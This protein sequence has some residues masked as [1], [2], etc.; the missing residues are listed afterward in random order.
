VI[1]GRLVVEELPESKEAAAKREYALKRAW[2]GKQLDSQNHIFVQ[3]YKVPAGCRDFVPERNRPELDDIDISPQINSPVPGHD[4]GILVGGAKIFDT[5]SLRQKLAGIVSQLASINAFSQSQI[6]AQYGSFQG[7]TRDTSYLAAQLT[8]S[9]TPSVV[10]TAGAATGNIVTTA[11]QPNTSIS[12]LQA[13]CP[14]GYLPQL[15]AGNAITCTIVNGSTQPYPV[16]AQTTTAN[17]LTNQ[18]VATANLPTNQIQTTTPSLTGTVPTAPTLNPLAP[19]AGA[20]ISSADMLDLQMQLGS[21]LTTLQT[22]LLGATSDQLLLSHQRA[23]GVRSQT[24]IGF[25]IT[26]LTPPAY[27]G[28]AA[29]VRMLILPR[30]SPLSQSQPKISIVNLLPL[31]KTYNV[32]RIT[33]NSKAFGAAVAIQPVSLGVSTGKAKDRLYL[34]K[35]TDTVALQYQPDGYLPAPRNWFYEA[36]EPNQECND[37]PQDVASNRDQYDFASAV[38]FG[39]QF[40]PVLGAVAVAPGLRTTFAQLALPQSDGAE[41]KPDVWVQ[42][43]WR[44]YDQKGQIAGRIYQSS[45]HW[46]KL[47]DPVSISNPIVVK[48]LQVDDVGQGLLRFRASGDFFSSTGQLRSGSLNVPPQFF[49]GNTIEYF[50]PAKDF[51]SNGDLRVLDEAMHGQPL[52]IPAKEE[53]FCRIA[54][55]SLSS[56][57]MADGTSRMRLEYQRQNYSTDEDKDGP[58]HPLLLLGSDVYGLRDKPLE[59]RK[60]TCTNSGTKRCSFVF[61]FLAATD[62]IR[63]AQSFLVRDPAWDS[64]GTI[65]KIDIGPA[66]A[67]IEAAGKAPSKDN[68]TAD[69]KPVQGCSAKPVPCPKPAQPAWYLLSGTNLS[70]LRSAAKLTADFPVSACI[71]QHGC[72]QILADGSDGTVHHVDS[73]EMSFVGDGEIWLKLLEPADVHVFWS[74]PGQVASEWALAIKT[75][76]K[77]AI[78][79]DPAVLY[80]ADSRAVTFTGPDFSKVQRVTYENKLL[81][82]PVKPTQ[83][84]LIVQVTSEVTLKFGH[85]ELI[86]HVVENGNEKNIALPLDVVQH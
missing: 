65:G 53:G 9:P 13:T 20:G 45:C 56:V 57:P 59:P 27:S 8:T 14:P 16:S 44:S 79:A 10:T 51:L 84:K 85:K 37:L 54:G 29:E 64:E 17:P 40:R 58:Q 77:P 43:R 74:R 34:A 3:V 78:T 39:W 28:A 69:P 30:T 81:E 61:E 11:N 49:D 86:A 33:S 23:F 47:S 46:E 73:S 6:T 75:D 12:T 15:G 19:P 52:I 5:F 22:L 68:K 72:L 70:V 55:A 80:V 38:M 60:P 48:D 66:F 82:L 4:N 63:S 26:V 76:D 83:S 42:T 31:E 24:T 25:P 41:F 1:N 36:R 50:E 32:A 35:D 2:E 67:K 71:N 18:V 62:S 21:Q 7:I